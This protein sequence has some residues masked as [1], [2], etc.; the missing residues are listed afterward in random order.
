MAVALARGPLEGADL[1][2][3]EPAQP[4]VRDRSLHARLSEPV[5]GCGQKFQRRMDSRPE[6]PASGRLG[7]AREVG[8]PEALEDRN[9]I[10]VIDP[11]QAVAFVQVGRLLSHPDRGGDA[12]RACDALA[13]LATQRSLDRAGHA[14]RA[15]TGQVGRPDQVQGRFIDRHPEHVR[16]M[17][18]HDLDELVGH[19]AVAGRVRLPDRDRRKYRLRLEHAHPRLDAKV[20]SFSGCGDDRRRIGRVC[21]Y[22]SRQTRS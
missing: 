19:G 7:D 20:P 6:E 4:H 15:E 17:A 16:G 11:L 8:E 13:G 5:C 22:R 3:F 2:P 12:H 1:E 10:G 21:R 14:F 9:E 18:P